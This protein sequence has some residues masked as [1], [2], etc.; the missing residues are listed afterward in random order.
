VVLSGIYQSKKGSDSAFCV[1]SLNLVCWHFLR[2]RAGEESSGEV[3]D[4]CYDCREVQIPLPESIVGGLVPEDEHETNDN[5]EAGDGC[6]W[7]VEM[8]VTIHIEVAY[9]RCESNM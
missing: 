2:V 1:R 5:R 6:A 3:S 9:D 4:A 7:Q 8:V